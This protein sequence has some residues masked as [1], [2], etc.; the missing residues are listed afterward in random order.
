MNTMN[1]I[2]NN[3]Y[4]LYQL[5]VIILIKLFLLNLIPCNKDFV[6]NIKTLKLINLVVDNRL[7]FYY[8]T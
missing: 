3:K 8:I 7:I 5:S 4:I 1:I 6:L 2:D